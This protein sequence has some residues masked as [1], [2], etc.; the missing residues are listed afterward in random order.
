MNFVLYYMNDTLLINYKIELEKINTNY[1]FGWNKIIQNF[2]GGWS[3]VLN[4]WHVNNRTWNNDEDYLNFINKN[5]KKE[6][7]KKDF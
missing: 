7:T 1:W 3:V 4:F 6:I 5:N 2:W